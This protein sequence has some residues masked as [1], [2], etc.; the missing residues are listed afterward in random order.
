MKT[1]L[2]IGP[3]FSPSSYPPSHRIRL[4]TNHLEEFDWKPIVLT[5]EPVYLEENLDWAFAQLIPKNLEVV[6]TK[7]FSTRWTRKLGIGDLGIRSFWFQL[8]AARR[9]CRQRKI[10]LV[11]IPGPPW[12]TFLVGPRLKRE[13]GIPYVM[14]Y[15]DPWVMSLGEHDPPWSKAYW[16]RKMAIFLEPYAVRHVDHIVAVSDGTND[17]VRCRYE[18]LS[19]EMCTGIPY[20]GELSDFEYVRQQPKENAFFDPR[21]GYFNFVYIGAMLPK[22]YDTLRTL[23]SAFLQLKETHPELYRRLR[24]Y[25][26][27]TT[28]AANPD[29]GLVKPVAD[30]MGVGDVIFEHPKRIPYLD[31]VD[32]LCQA[33]GILVL[34]TTEI[35][36][37]ASKIYPCIMANKP[38]LAMFHRA[39]SVVDVMTLTN[40]GELITYDSRETVEFKVNEISAAMLKI[41]SPGYIKPETKW[42][43]FEK[44]SARSMTVR[45]AAV[46]DKVT[47]DGGPV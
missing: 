2:I 40:S 24:C 3:C 23:F 16:F 45:L 32:V 7:A 34:G 11:F 31:A 38:I 5:V 42:D 29:N 28:Y 17:G 13:F 22:A 33:D 46:F 1:V 4:F 27:G 30:E 37:T 44:Y 14:D 21:D 8:Q 19:P 9:V 20:G 39:S 43:E 26:I 15:I 18:F 10:D 35:H 12:H 47:N 41:I 25:F 36:Y 6:R